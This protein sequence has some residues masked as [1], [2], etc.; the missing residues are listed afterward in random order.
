MG[1]RRGADTIARLEQHRPTATT[2]WHHAV[3]SD[4]SAA[5]RNQAYRPRKT[6]EKSD[7]TEL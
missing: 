1:H 6:I 2:L 4:C 7:N 5:E 3:A